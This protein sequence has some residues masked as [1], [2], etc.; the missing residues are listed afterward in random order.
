MLENS[1][2][3]SLTPLRLVCGVRFQ[4]FAQRVSTIVLI[5]FSLADDVK[6][7]INYVTIFVDAASAILRGDVV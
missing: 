6:N 7:Q 5:H 1:S 4:A 3:P 2:L